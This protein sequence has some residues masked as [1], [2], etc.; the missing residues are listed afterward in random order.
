M[1]VKPGIRLLGVFMI[2]ISCFVLVFIALSLRNEQFPYQAIN[3][4]SLSIEAQ[5]HLKGKNQIELT[6]NLLYFVGSEGKFAGVIRQTRLEDGKLRIKILNSYVP[7]DSIGPSEHYFTAAKT[8]EGYQVS[9]YKIR[10]SCHRYRSN[11]SEL[12]STFISPLWTNSSCI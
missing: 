7:D 1:K 8:D 6:Q 11:W 10:K 12:V 4:N 9:E 3:I 5:D 2:I